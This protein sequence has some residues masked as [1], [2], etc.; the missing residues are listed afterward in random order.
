[1]PSPD[2]PKARFW[3]ALA[4]DRTTMVGLD[5]DEGGHARPMTGQFEDEHSPIWFFAAI[6]GDLV[7]HLAEHDPAVA[8]FTAKGYDPAANVHGKLSLDTDPAVTD[9]LW[10][11]YIAAWY[12]GKDDPI[13]ALLRLDYE[14]AE[15]RRAGSSSPAYIK[16][17]LRHDPKRDYAENAATVALD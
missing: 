14:E 8:T 9:R 16:T 13:L 6:D 10:N 1:M 5:G 7:T 12:A 11:S 2:K 17:M 4:S 3:S 15:I